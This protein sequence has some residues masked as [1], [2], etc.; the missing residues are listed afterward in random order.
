MRLRTAGAYF[1]IDGVDYFS[2]V[3]SFS[4]DATTNS[5][6]T[7]GVLQYSHSLSPGTHNVTV[8]IQGTSTSMNFDDSSLFIQTY[9]S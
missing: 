6:T 9:L 7:T 8:K 3:I 5:L 1:V 4:V 2:T